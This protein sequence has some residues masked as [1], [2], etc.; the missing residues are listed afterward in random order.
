MIG[1]SDI[2]SVMRE[3]GWVPALLANLIMSV[4]AA[5]CSLMLLRAMTLIPHN[6]NF[7]HRIEYNALVK[8]Y[9]SDNNFKM[10][11]FLHHTGTLCSVICGILAFSKLVD[12]LLVQVL[13]W[14]LALQVY[15]HASIGRADLTTVTAIYE[16][17]LIQGNGEH[18]ITLAITL[19][20]VV[21]ALLCLR[22]SACAL[23]ETM[24]F[25]VFSF[26][27]F[28]GCGLQLAVFGLLRSARGG[29]ALKP[30]AIGRQRFGKV[31]LTF[32]ENFSVAS[33]TPS[34]ANEM[35][36][37]V[38]VMRTMWAST[39]FTAVLYH[40]LGYVFCFAYPEGGGSIVSGILLSN[41]GI[42]A[43]A[44]ICFFVAVNVLPDVV[45]GTISTRYNLLN[46][47]YCG[48]R[49]AYFWGCILPFTFT[50]LLSNESYFFD[51]LGQISLVSSLFCDFVVPVIV[52]KVAQ[53]GLLDLT[54][55]PHS[56][57]E[58]SLFSG[59]APE[60]PAAL[61]KRS[62]S[63]LF[64]K[65]TTLGRAF[66]LDCI[67]KHKQ[68][69]PPIPEVPG[70]VKPGPSRLD[71]TI[72][73]DTGQVNYGL[74]KIIRA[75][76]LPREDDHQ[77][78]VIA[79]KK[80][81][82]RVLFDYL[83]LDTL[84]DDSSDHSS[85]TPSK[86]AEPEKRVELFPIAF[87]ER[88]NGFVSHVCALKGFSLH[89]D[90]PQQT[91]YFSLG[92]VLPIDN[93]THSPG[94]R[95][96]ADCTTNGYDNAKTPRFNWELLLPQLPSASRSPRNTKNPCIAGCPY[97]TWVERLGVLRA[98]RNDIAQQSS[99][100][101]LTPGLDSCIDAIDRLLRTT[102]IRESTQLSSVR[103]V[104]PNISG[105]TDRI[106]EKGVATVDYVDNV[107]KSPAVRDHDISH[108]EDDEIPPSLHLEANVAESHFDALLVRRLYSRRWMCRIEAVDEIISLLDN[109][110]ILLLN[111][112]SVQ[113]AVTGV[114]M[115]LNRLFQDHA[116]KVL[117]K[118]LEL[119]DAFFTFMERNNCCMAQSARSYTSSGD[120][121]RGAPVQCSLDFLEAI[122]A[123]LG[124]RV[125]AVVNCAICA[126]LKIAESNTIPTYEDITKTLLKSL[127]T[128]N[129]QPG[130]RSICNRLRMLSTVLLR[131]HLY[132][133][134]GTA[135]R[136]VRPGTFFDTVSALCHH[137]HGS[138]RSAAM[139]ALAV[140]AKAHFHVGTPPVESSIREAMDRIQLN[141]VSIYEGD[142]A[143]RTR[144]L[145][146]EAQA[147]WS[148]DILGARTARHGLDNAGKT[149]ILKRLNGEDISRIEPTLGF[150]IKTLEHNGYQVN[151]WDVGGQKTIRSFWRNYFENTDA[152]VWVVDSADTLRLEDSRTEI[153]ELLR[154]DQMAQ[155]TLLVFANKQDVPGA[156]SVKA[157]QEQLGLRQVA[158][159]RSWAIHGCSGVTG[160][161]LE[162]LIHQ[163]RRDPEAHRDDFFLKWEEFVASFA[164][165]RLTPHLYNADAMSL[166]NFVAQRNENIDLRYVPSAAVDSKRVSSASE[167]I[168]NAKADPTSTPS[169]TQS[170]PG[171]GALKGDTCHNDLGRELCMM[172][173]EFIK[174]H[175][176]GMNGKTL[177]Q[178]LS[179]TFLLRSKRLIDIFTILPEWLA[180]LDLDERDSRR[181]LFVFIVR[182]LTI[183]SQ[184][185]KD[186]RVTK[187][188]QRLF[189]D[190]LRAKS[191]QVQLLTC[192][193]C[194]EMHK[195]RLWRDEYTVNN[196]AQCALASNLKLVLAGAHFL[197]GTRNHF[198][199][200][201]EALEDLEEDIAALEN[202]SKQQNN[203]AAGAHSKKSEGRQNRLK[204]TKKQVEKQLER[205]KKRL[206]LCA[207]REFAAIDELHDPQKFTERLF[208]RCRCKDVTFGAKLIL[209]QLVSILIARHR[210]LVPSF[211]GFVLKYINH[212]QK[213]V[214]KIL[215]ISAQAVHTDLPPDLVDPVIRQVMDQFVS[216][217]RSNEVI[218]AG[219]NTLRE[220]AARAPLLFPQ[221]LISQI[222]EFR[223]IKNKGKHCFTST[224]LSTAVSMAT[225][226]F[227]NLYREQAPEM[228]HP[229]LRGREA[230]T[231]LTKA[232]KGKAVN[233]GRVFSDAYILSQE[234]FKRKNFTGPE[235]IQAEDD[236]SAEEEDEETATDSQE[237]SDDACES[238]DMDED[239]GMDEDE[240][241]S[242]S[243]G[244]DAI[245]DIDSSNKVRR[246]GIRRDDTD[247]IDDDD[248]DDEARLK[249]NPEDLMYGS[250]RKRVAA[251][252]RR[253]A[254]AARIERKKQRLTAESRAGNR[255]STTNRV[256]AR[257]KPVLMTLQSKRVKTKQT[258]NIAEKMAAL[259]RH[260]KSLKK[261]NVKHK[262][263]RR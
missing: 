191:V 75:P 69:E 43:H 4:L 122:V 231:Q 110:A 236:A 31:L 3:S 131:S 44:T 24:G 203:P 21:C 114:C 89:K 215:A 263:R 34:W 228:L 205:R 198:D 39:F 136:S 97:S 192:C 12:M 7:D 225:K 40:V 23:E 106:S 135:R 48:Q 177:R 15:P 165:L 117:I 193:I 113:R 73:D 5:L 164:V 85:T 84:D 132:N 14:T 229:T 138:V 137:S 11:T 130:R 146:S 148:T 252:T 53:R 56:S 36:R 154:Q 88:H 82:N 27:A 243:E 196:I 63:I 65:M 214:T 167:N 118:S 60:T 173:I 172:L 202:L 83:D 35:T 46:L 98:T 55:S 41:S 13:G 66:T 182:D 201:F 144:E 212:K 6:E 112:G 147:I 207:V 28:I 258:Q 59:E 77:Y 238:G 259:K 80:R 140:G 256:K 257:S 111:E 74:F 10:V 208:E 100:S 206:E 250:K 244:E 2:P 128:Y 67:I 72:D 121:S 187:A 29:P 133:S 152:L 157:I 149:T 188:V 139:E 179:T 19:G 47:G 247:E 150:N 158:N 107:S 116:L 119:L 90:E 64:K 219:V 45:F 105:I 25:H 20:Y 210:L 141:L 155:C 33:S 241:G 197:L 37:D 30:P 162:H 242:D 230:G 68:E 103:D 124:D 49:A 126:L 245:S 175:R 159:E 234:D 16:S 8:Y 221:E 253:D 38:K 26:L 239:E 145:L 174:T 76:L 62:T 99:L 161:G 151:F 142:A 180:L 123:R 199:V 79:T 249:V 91:E 127:G 184:Q 71:T 171:A 70:C 218:T 235:D 42:V 226:S 254:A 115:A 190:Y 93:P 189:F 248:D 176:K 260:L 54:V 17:D 134:H 178:V 153:E 86:R 166:L 251:E 95:L 261:G 216:E 108:D 101:H 120:T 102:L 194:V 96:I 233:P 227:I 57:L 52:Y 81:S 50:W 255:Q 195:R 94:A 209:L 237:G 168:R 58:G 169:G 240:Y 32:V 185:M 186:V 217:D 104:Y 87:L 61:L 18:S 213:L 232:K 78:N 211:Y 9:L 125:S 109:D 223:N 92:E 262:K 224:Q 220:I 129:S 163:I 204:R 22:L 1:M 156:M 183:V 222:V 143:S 160:E 181:R 246:S 200:A 51:Y 170:L